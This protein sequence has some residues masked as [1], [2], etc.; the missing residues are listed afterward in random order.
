MNY[1]KVLII[2]EQFDRR[3]GSGITLSNLFWGWNIENIAVA[4]SEIF[5]PDVSVCNKYYYLGYQEIKWKFPFN[6]KLL[7]Q[8]NKPGIT[9]DLLKNNQMAPVKPSESL[10][11]KIQNKVITIS[12]IL[13]RRREIIISQEF[14][15]WVND[16]APE[17][18]YTQLSSFEL[19]E[20]VSKFQKEFNLP[21]VIHIMD[22]WPKTIVD[23]QRFIFKHYWKALIGKN[24]KNLFNSADL[25]LS[26][27]DAMSDEY[28]IRYSLNFIPFHNPIDL[29]HWSSGVVKNYERKKVFR[30]LY[31]GRIGKGLRNSLFEVASAIRELLEN[32]TF[33]IELQIQATSDD[34]ILDKLKRFNFVKI[35]PPVEYTDLP[36]IF[37]AADLLLLPNDFDNKSINFLKYSMPTKAS[38]YMASGTPILLYSHHD[39][40]VTKHAVK[41]NWAYVV[42][43]RSIPKLKEAI[44]KLYLEMELRTNV[45]INAQKFA[46]EH[47]DSS[48]VR[49]YF[50]DVLYNA[51]R[52]KLL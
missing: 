33:Q 40:A 46:F 11:K 25:L 23:G 34:G 52:S 12:G 19:I 49:A 7:T 8:K 28:K 2:G 27:S 48:I 38:E 39:T 20:F 18:I 22:D 13:H 14:K 37:S 4:S 5:S 15:N 30:I 51:S 36:K 45:G 1:P 43:E 6:L 29:N 21:L 35:N 50:R 32:E 24:L 16:F 17:L 47:Y 41:N 10:L 9:A 31:A 26:I 3:S 42:A 44:K